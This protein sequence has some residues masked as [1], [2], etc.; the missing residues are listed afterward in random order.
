MSVKPFKINSCDKL[1]YN[2]KDLTILSPE[3][4]YG[5]KTKPRNIIQK[6]NIP[7]TEYVYG[8]LK[9]NEWNLTTEECK[10]AQLLVTKDWIDKYFFTTIKNTQVTKKTN[11]VIINKTD[12]ENNDK[13]NDE[14]EDE[15][16]DENDINNEDC[17]N[18]PPEI[19]LE[20]G[21]KFKDVNG[22]IIEIETRGEKY[23]DKIFFKVKDVMKGFNMT[24]LHIHI[25]DKNSGYNKNIDYKYF[26]N[27]VTLRNTLTIKKSLYLTYEGM[28]RVLFVSRNENA[29]KFRKWATNKIFTIQMG[30]KEEKQKLGTHILKVDLKTFKA[31]FDSY[32]STF[33]CIYLLS[34]GKV[35]DLRDTFNISNDINDTSTVYKYGFTE[36][37]ERRLRE[38]T[39]EYGKM[40]NVDI[41]LSIFHM[42]DNKYMSKAE[43]DVKHLFNVFDKSLNVDSTDETLNKK[44]K[45]IVVLNDKEYKQ[46]N[47][48]YKLIGL[49]YI[50][51][52]Q[53]LQDKV[54]ELQNEIKIIN[55]NKEIEV[56]KLTN[57]NE[58]L[59]R[60][61]QTNA[62]IHEL[63][64][65]TLEL[66][67]KLLK[68]NI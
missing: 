55:L 50:G 13:N 66:E 17:E 41:S 32:A 27:R 11:D 44:R 30:S 37:L 26:F 39:S 35:N 38:H 33:P 14:N 20:D 59:K 31:V 5:C 16:N 67:L 68:N 53:F 56:Q 46:I 42:V 8:N 54:Q 62:K 9:K 57:E 48:H 19:Y 29:T 40:K 18:A 28:L 52:T 63:E 36:D 1:Y 10:K 58:M 61:I 3:F 6:K 25:I 51:S 2:M 65:R 7:T 47:E 49:K 21:E 64:K 15:N 12:N 23:E 60:E 4:F 22:N 34:L 43:N 45:E 24:N